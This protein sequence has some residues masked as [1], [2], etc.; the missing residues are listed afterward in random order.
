MNEQKWKF[1]FIRWR[2]GFQI[3][4][5]GDLGTAWTEPEQLEGNMIGG[6]GLGFR[7]EPT[8]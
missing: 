8:L 3:A 4:A 5:F 1:W 7:L 2:M 6:G